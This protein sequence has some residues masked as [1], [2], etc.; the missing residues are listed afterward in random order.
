MTVQICRTSFT[1]VLLHLAKAIL[2]LD[3]YDNLFLY[4]GQKEKIY[5]NTHLKIQ[6][7]RVTWR[8]Q[9]KYLFKLNVPIFE[10]TR[11][12]RHAITFEE[13]HTLQ[14][15]RMTFETNYNIRS[16][17][18]P[19]S[20]D[21]VA[22]LIWKAMLVLQPGH[23]FFWNCSCNNWFF[24]FLST[25][26]FKKK[27]KGLPHLQVLSF[28]VLICMPEIDGRIYWRKKYIF[29]SLL[30]TWPCLDRFQNLIN[31]KFYK[32]LSTW[33]CEIKSLNHFTNSYQKKKKSQNWTHIWAIFIHV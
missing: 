26:I 9:S 5:L 8:L 3:P 28:L 13:I 33:S 32:H 27:K 15:C 24:I 2:L 12:L 1:F 10:Q 6:I 25:F 16:N 14:F 23:F 21:N 29:Q 17:A 4:W 30:W 19:I 31:S 11:K 18:R 7:I 22:M 20:C